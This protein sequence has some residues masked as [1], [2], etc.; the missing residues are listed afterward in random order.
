MY[1]ILRRIKNFFYYKD[2]E[3]ADARLEL[4][5]HAFIFYL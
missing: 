3:T 2:E 5:L 4:N 1:L